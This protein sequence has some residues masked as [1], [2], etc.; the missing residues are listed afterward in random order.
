V[1]WPERISGYL[2]PGAAEQ[3]PGFRGEIDRLS[4]LSLRVTGGVQIGVSLFMLAARFLISPESS[5]LPLRFRQGAFIIALG[6]INIAVSRLAARRPWLAH[7]ARALATISGVLV[8]AV[9]I[10]ASLAISA[11]STNPN[12]FIPGQITLVILIA[13]TLV[14]LRPMHTLALGLAIGVDYYISAA[15]AERWLMEGL[16]PDDNYLLFIVM[17]TLLSTGITAVVY[18]QRHSH[19]QILQQTVEAGEAL[20][21]AQARILLSESAASLSRLAAAVSHEMNN[22]L[23]VLLS[24]VDTLLLL[25]ARQA[26]STPEEQP[27]L[28]KLQ[29]EVRRSVQE[30]I[31]RLKELIGRMQRFTNLD[32]AEVQATDINELLK[33]VAAL[34]DPQLKQGAGLELH[35]EPIPPLVCR[36]QQLSAVFSSLLN[37]AMQAVNGDGR[38]V[39]ST[40]QNE[41]EVEVEI[42]DNGRGVDPEELANIFDPG[43]RVSG[44]RMAASNWSLFNS[45]QIVREHG[46]DIRIESRPGR[47]TRIT[48]AI[49][50]S[51][52]PSRLE[53]QEFWRKL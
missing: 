30:S 53:T 46:G 3:D 35:L 37:N 5:T 25:G 26:T 7:W 41:Q 18:A 52:D 21:Q 6:I 31:T 51:N 13:V 47:G 32:Q 9:L 28:V 43:F 12:D 45:R 20:R 14:P 38:I 11:R 27:R 44:G 36:P 50:I 15:L 23:G 42:S 39:I 17:L 29:A 33:D 19:Y 34:V 16:G 40:R 8:A 24:G 10:W 22:P 49:P 2:F 48:V 4:L 1:T